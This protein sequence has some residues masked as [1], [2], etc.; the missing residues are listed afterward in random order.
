M[1]AEDVDKLISH[2]DEI[3]SLGEAHF[4]KIE[5]A[6]YRPYPLNQALEDVK[7]LVLHLESFERQLETHSLQYLKVEKMDTPKDCR[8]L[9][10]ECEKNSNEIYERK[11]KIIKNAELTLKRLAT[12]LKKI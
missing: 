6:L 5:K 10:D 2:L 8:E 9:A 3:E 1:S 7:L 4:E 11:Q 12:Q